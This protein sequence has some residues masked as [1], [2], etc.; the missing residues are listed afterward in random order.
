MTNCPG[1]CKRKG[2]QDMGLSVLKPRQTG[3]G[4]LPYTLASLFLG[5]ELEVIVVLLAKA[6]APIGRLDPTASYLL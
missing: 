3:M 5:Q 6:T 1:L 4:W 2:S